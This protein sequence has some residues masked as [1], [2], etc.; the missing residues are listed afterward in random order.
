M[1]EGGTTFF[2]GCARQTRIREQ[3]LRY[4]IVNVIRSWLSYV[5]AS[6][7]RP[8]EG[9]RRKENEPNLDSVQSYHYRNRRLRIYDCQKSKGMSKGLQ[10]M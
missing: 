8:E 2:L 4:V 6:K 3:H 10:C 7:L 1:H 9:A 5:R